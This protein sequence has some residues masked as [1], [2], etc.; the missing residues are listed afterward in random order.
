M[1][2]KKETR[3][4]KPKIRRKKKV[5]RKLGDY[6]DYIDIYTYIKRN[7]YVPRMKMVKKFRKSRTAMFY[8]LNK[9]RKLKILVTHK[10]KTIND[11]PA[12]KNLLMWD[13]VMYS[14]NK[15]VHVDDM[16]FIVDIDGT[17]TTNMF[18]KLGKKSYKSK[19]FLKKLTGLKLMDWIRN[20]KS[21]LKKGYRLFFITGR[22]ELIEGLTRE[23]LEK[24]LNLINDDYN[25]EFI[26]Y[27]NHEMYIIEKYKYIKKII[28]MYKD[29]YFV[30]LEDDKSIIK[31]LKKDDK[32]KKSIIPFNIP[33]DIGLFKS[34]A[35]LLMTNGY[36]YR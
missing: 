31:I 11:N 7:E 1:E 10:E 28:S 26:G 5:G 2:E 16:I 23:W 12:F 14:L 29:K 32:I 33:V 3:G 20:I 22:N 18:K 6:I 27:I 9:M 17:L 25:I 36:K 13:S 15:N 30:V 8:A 35:N 34:F 21:I 19:K 4:R 24:N